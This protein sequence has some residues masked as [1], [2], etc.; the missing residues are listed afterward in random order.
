[1]LGSLLTVLLCAASAG[2]Q[3][4]GVRAI[5]LPGHAVAFETGGEEVARYRYDGA[6][7]NPC[8][9]PFIG[10][11]G[12][13]VTRMSHPRDPHGH[14]HHRSI[15]V[16]HTDVDG[17]DFWT[18]DGPGRVIHDRLVS[19]EDGD[20]AASMT[21]QL[22]WQGPEGA[23]I[24]RE[25]RTLTV[26]ERADGT[27]RYVDLALVFTPAGGAP[28]TLG[29]T[30]FGFLGVRV[31]KPM[32][33]EFGD[34]RIVNSEGAQQEAETFGKPARWVAY[35]GSAAPGVWQGVAVFD[36]PD[37]PGHPVAWH[38]RDDGWVGPSFCRHK[39]HTI[40]PGENLPLRYRVYT[41]GGGI[42]QEDIAAFWQA[43]AAE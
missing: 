42:T 12:H 24:L 35:A 36:H 32:S 7:V 9:F 31:A 34:G 10:P 22:R 17:V 15:W 40:E 29:K 26:G 13:R 3:A 11:A 37:N 21:V 1:M 6:D 5:P 30:N 41:F 16:A 8:I 18:N 43:F 27:G 39:A 25:K 20:R 14:G 23:D 38:V 2:P 4:P 33:V 28:V 19:M